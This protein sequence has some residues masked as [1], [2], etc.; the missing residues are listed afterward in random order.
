M[1]DPAFLMLVGLAALVA[2]ANVALVLSG[3]L[4]FYF[5]IV[6]I[7]AALVAVWLAILQARG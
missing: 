4:P 2:A 1:R 3:L 6:S 7:L 5:G